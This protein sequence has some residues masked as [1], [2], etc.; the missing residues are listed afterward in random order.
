VTLILAVVLVLLVGFLV[1]KKVVAPRRESGAERK[2]KEKVRPP[3][4]SGRPGSVL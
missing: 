3:T 2:P 1:Y 4:G